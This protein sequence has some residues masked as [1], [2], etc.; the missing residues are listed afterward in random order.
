MES[1]VRESTGTKCFSLT[2]SAQHI[3][4]LSGFPLLCQDVARF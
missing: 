2:L 1:Y 3:P 4:Q